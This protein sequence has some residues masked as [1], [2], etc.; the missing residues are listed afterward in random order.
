MDVRTVGQ[1][2]KGVPKYGGP[3]RPWPGAKMNTGPDVQNTR[4]AWPFKGNGADSFAT[5]MKRSLFFSLFAT[6]ISLS[7][8]GGTPD[9]PAAVPPP[10]LHGQSP[11]ADSVFRT[12]DLDRQIA[13]LM[14]VAAYSNRD[15]AHATETEALVRELGI[16]G[17]IFFQ[18]GPVRQATLTNR[19]QAASKVP[20]WIGMD[21]E[22]GLGMRLDS[23]MK[24]PR[25]MTLGALAD[26]QGLEDMGAEIARQM[27]R[28]GVQVS[29]SPDV[30][31][32]IDPANPVIN[33]RSFGEDPDRVAEKGIAYMRGLQRGG[34]LATAKHFPGHGDTD[35]DSHKTLPVVDA[36]R[37]RLDS[38]ELMPFQ[39]LI[40]AGVGAVM[41]AHLQ[42]PALDSTPGLPSTLSRPIVTG[43]LQRDM[44]F[45]GLVFT[46]A[47]NMKGVADADKPGEIEVRALLAG[48]DVLLFPQD[49][50]KAVAA[51]RQA[52]DSGLI[53]PETIAW[54]CMKVLRAKAWAS[55]DH[56]AP[57]ATAGLYQDLNRPEA[58]ALR[59]DLYAQAL[60]VANNKGLLPIRDLDQLKIASLV[61]GDSV[62]N[63]FQQA[64]G[65]YA[66]M[67]RMACPKVLN[68]AQVRT[69]LD[70]LADFDLVIASVHSTST[71]AKK[72]FGVPQI[73]LDFLRRLNDRQTTVNVLFAN[74]YR[75][76]GAIGA[77][78]W[79][80]VVVAYEENDDTEDLA[81]QVL[82]GARPATGRLPVSAS[83]YFHQGKGEEL[84][85]IGRLRYGIPE[86][87]AMRAVDL[88]TV[89]S[90]VQNGIATGAMPGCQ[91]IAVRDGMVV[92]D[93]AYGSPTYAGQRAVRTDDI[94]DLA[95]LTKVMATTLALMK[96]S[97]SGEVDVDQPLGHYLPEVRSV[98]AYAALTL[99][100][101]LAHQAG[102]K[103]FLP[104]YRNIMEGKNF[105]SGVV[106][107]R[108]DA[109]H[110][111]RVAEGLYISPAYPDSILKWILATPISHRGEYLYSDMGMYLLQRVVEQVADMPL[112]RYVQKEFYGP[113]G[114]STMGYRPLTRFPKE[115]LMPTERDTVFRKQLVQGDVHDPGAALMGG[116]A[117]HAGLFADANDVAIVLQMLLD[118]GTYGGH[119][120]LKRTT[121]EQFTTCR[122]CTGKPGK[123]NRR[124]LGWDKPT[125][126]G[127]PG[128]ACSKA[129][130]ASFGH[131]GFTG[132]VAWADPRD[133][134]I[135]VFLSNRVFPDA[136]NKKLIHMDIRTKVQCVLHQAMAR[137]LDPGPIPAISGAPA[138]P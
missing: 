89:D 31:V 76:A 113:L 138:Q 4:P 106:A 10:F 108:P 116:V 51:I 91:V 97:D 47:L 122:Y 133:R 95:S 57:I 33:E 99:S 15:E 20:L 38:V 19:Y 85:A 118:G 54:K 25:Q 127:T 112:D 28:L 101:I 114:L 90:I 125:P 12:L 35:A 18:G 43:L 128:P 69:L 36:T 21:L 75:L 104:F 52:V 77:A 58:L 129:S 45:Q 63:R 40:D 41:V 27:K 49:P 80:A 120:Y 67:A 46:D 137:S 61:I 16:G 136:N 8:G 92:L 81:A 93:K 135:Y 121:V 78:R 60:T 53:A 11:W 59:R 96:L 7:F 74:P 24:F 26:D 3:F 13:Q 68:A 44:G 29:F 83:P 102:L 37:A 73:T 117:G 100:E 111:V 9:R 42:V 23:T 6:A 103:P 79:K 48:N 110:A 30:D 130:T 109:Q 22:W 94:Y 82:F 55:L 107:D 72:E 119:R 88:A 98:P 132:T 105:R 70:S 32:N 39:R 131:T 123:E 64:L 126:P 86:E 65:R 56:W 115:R 62:G 2:G 14:M 66:P 1:R 134:S 87:E 17:L 50:R 5:G 124:G 71:Q 84:A 34:V